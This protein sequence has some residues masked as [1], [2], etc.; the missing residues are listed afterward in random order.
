MK[1][2]APLSRR[3]FISTAAAVA[4]AAALP[5]GDVAFSQT[6]IQ[7]GAH[8]TLDPDWATA[9]IIATRHS[10]YAKL[11]SVPVNAVTITAGFWS[12]R[13]QTNVEASIPSMRTELIDHGRMENFLRL[14]GKATG[15][16]RGP[17][18]S[19]SDIYKWMEAV[20]F[21]LQSGPQPALRATTEEMIRQVVAAQ[22]PSGYL[23]TYFVD[24][25]R[26]ERMLPKTQIGGH[27]LY[28]LGHLLQGGIAYYRATGD[29]TLLNAGKRFVDDYLLPGY[30]PAASQDPIVAGHP[31][32][33]MSL[34]ELYRTT[35]KRRVSRPGW[36]HSAGRC[37]YSSAAAADR[38]YVLRG[39]VYHAHQ[40]RRPRRARHVCVLWGD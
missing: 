34:I 21:T 17:V 32:I 11:K 28:C 24:S 7:G 9:G 4:A 29:P 33:E 30:G 22:E 26:A 23:N 13:R 36:L 2:A 38:L 27:E 5:A 8:A 1:T 6:S 20:G 31:E 18:Y 15:P 19:D 25:H 35:G 10:P 3:Q 16:Q 39:A 12:K 37:A 14:E 40:A